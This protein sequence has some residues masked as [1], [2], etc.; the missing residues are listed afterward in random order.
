MGSGG[1][2]MDLTISAEK[3]DD[4]IILYVHGEVDAYTAPRL[5]ERLAPLV[6]SG[7][8]PKVTVDLERVSYMDSTGIGIFIG[9]LKASKQS[10]CQLLLQNVTPRVERLFRITGLHEIIPITLAKGEE[11]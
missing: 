7:E 11:A 5:N 8:T 10:G 9:A 2:K 6:L 1:K 4:A 3:K